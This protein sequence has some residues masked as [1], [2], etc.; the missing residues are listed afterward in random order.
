MNE[1]LS[2]EA[3]READ[4]VRLIVAGEL[5]LSTAGNLESVL[6]QHQ[7]SG[8][9]V[10]IDLSALEFIDSTGLQLLLRAQ[11]DARRDGWNLAFAS[12]VTPAVQRLLE[13]TSARPLLDWASG[14]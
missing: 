2:V 1:V 11:A 12:S 7:G 3:V 14:T 4:H 9:T 8:R 10:L 6:Q 13:L 5:D